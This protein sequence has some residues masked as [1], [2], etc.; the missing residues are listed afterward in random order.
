MKRKS[1]TPGQVRDVLIKQAY[2]L[3]S[4]IVCPLCSGPMYPW[5]PLIREDM[6]AVAL[7]GVDGPENWRYVHKECAH[8]KTFGTKATTAGS[9][10]HLIAK[11]K[12]LRGE[13]GQNRRKAKIKSP[14]FKKDGPKRKIQSRGFARNKEV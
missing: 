1:P 6:H 12:R 7:G 13:T 8:K 2:E 10:I 4:P 9:D 5:Q 3:G 11:G 14:G